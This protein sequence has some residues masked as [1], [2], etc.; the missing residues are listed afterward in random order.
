MYRVEYLPEAIADILEARLYL[1]QHSPAAA[2]KLA[3]AI[4]DKT[5]RL[6]TFPLLYTT[7]EHDDSLHLM[8]L[9]YQY[10]CF[11]RVDEE[12]KVIQVY[13]VLRGMRDIPSLL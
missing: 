10:L 7:Y 3:Q 13:R 9:P 8:P 12:N 2:N 6:I 1:H 4:E 5:E 11:Y